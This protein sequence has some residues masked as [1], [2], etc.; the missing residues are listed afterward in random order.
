MRKVGCQLKKKKNEFFIASFPRSGNTWVRFLIANVYNNIK[1][2]FPEV[3]FFNIH[4]IV[5]ELKKFGEVVKPYFS[6]LP[7]VIKT[8][9]KF[10]DSFE[11]TILVLRNPFD[12]IY[13]YN[14]FLNMNRGIKISLPEMV[15]HEK[16]GIDAIVDHTNSFIR[17]CDNLLITSYENLV[18]Q[19]LK[20]LKK[21]CDFLNIS[22]KDEII[23]KSV[24][25]S[26][27]RSM[28]E[29]ELRKGR[30]FGKKDFLFTRNGKV[31][32]GKKEIQEDEKLNLF[33]LN[34]LK[35]SPILYL[36]YL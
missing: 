19:P 35:K 20:E 9:S 33:I 16:Y 17:N 10:I 11:N 26:S 3:D 27:F 28:R 21:I 29:I 13:S 15:T 7:V 2:E 34:V 31:G 18:C 12:T 24:K 14:N 25:K 6:D 4:D 8:H 1:K 32:E 23:K 5:P 22:V 36:L 30:K